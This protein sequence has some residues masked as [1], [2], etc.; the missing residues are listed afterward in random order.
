MKKKILA[1]LLGLIVSMQSVGLSVSSV[2]AVENDLLQIHDY[3]E[4]APDAAE[5]QI[6]VVTDRSLH[7]SEKCSDAL[8]QA[9]EL[10]AD[11]FEVII[12][13]TDIETAEMNS[14]IVNRKISDYRETLE[15]EGCC[16]DE[17]AEKC[18]EYRKQLNEECIYA[19]R[20]ERAEQILSDLNINKEDAI[21]AERS[22]KI[23][24][25]LTSEQLGKA[26]DNEL[27]CSIVLSS[28]LA[29]LEGT[30]EILLSEASENTKPP[31]DEEEPT[32]VV[33]I[34]D[35]FKGDAG[36]ESE[37]WKSADFCGEDAPDI[38]TSEKELI[39]QDSDIDPNNSENAL[40][41]SDEQEYICSSKPLRLICTN[42]NEKEYFHGS[43]IRK[44]FELRSSFDVDAYD[45]TVSSC[46]GV[47]ITKEPVYV[48]DAY[49]ITSVVLE[50]K[51]RDAYEFGNI[52]FSISPSAQEGDS[53]E[54]PA[55]FEQNIYCYHDSDHD[56]VSTISLDCLSDCSEKLRDHLSAINRQ[57]ECI[58]NYGQLVKSAKAP[59]SVT[60]YSLSVGGYISWTDYNGGVHPAEDLTVMVFTVNGSSRSIIAIT[61][62][63]SAGG[64]SCSI[65]TDGS[66][67]NILVMVM[68]QGTNV[69]VK[70]TSNTT[71]THEISIT[72]SVGLAKVSYTAPNNTDVGKSISIQQAM[73]LANKYIYSLDSAYLDNVNVIFP[74]NGGS[75]FSPSLKTIYIEPNDEFDW[76]VAQHEYGHYVQHTYNIANS[77]GGS[78]TLSGNLADDRKNKSAG[79]R[80]AWGEGWA[81]YFAINLQKEM[82]AAS[83][84]IPNV[85]DTHYQDIGT[86]IDLDIENLPSYYWKG[87]ANEATVC[88]VLYDM[89]DG[90]NSSEDDHVYFAN[91]NIW[92][93]TKSNHCT[94]LSQFITAFYAASFPFSTRLDLGSTLSRYK[95][96]AKPNA[97]T[98]IT[99]NTPT[100]SWVNQ[101]GSVN[102]PNN[103]FRLAFYD[104]NYNLILRTDYT[105]A[106]SQVLTAAQWTQ[107]KN[108]DSTVYYLVESKQT[109]S[110]ETG[111][112]Y[113][114]KKT[115]TF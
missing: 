107:I 112:Y 105:T 71:Y 77:P 38:N 13:Y 59:N 56:Y 26:I 42:E 14:P 1:A 22:A 96:A 53:L 19:L 88:A 81:T 100:F 33:T 87:E 101:G 46:D 40:E 99:T 63:S 113:S 27:V 62:T 52:C 95:V 66:S 24:C 111:S 30:A 91:N 55:S 110:P 34:T 114:T 29:E 61:H 21:C 82:A 73:A 92:D 51:V 5:M 79:I 108:A 25:V 48:V 78:H 32:T 28:E 49:G 60:D 97:P 23:L 93:I 41:S 16:A 7:F 4:N 12:T 18:T 90:H 109:N 58:D 65:P 6:P 8:I 35:V 106:S 64:Y 17:I 44:E 57:G 70:N 85:G 94:T 45:I 11:S 9:L 80:L 89:T 76:D 39:S 84:N 68:S 15:I 69:T 3:E 54:E 10:D 2:G 103:K 86:S 72:A 20:T 50:F 102:Y 104:H 31:T 37:G 75:R 36:A 83:L 47:D 74:D 67:K 43:V 115:L 98:G